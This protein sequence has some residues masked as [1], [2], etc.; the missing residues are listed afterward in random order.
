MG[1]MRRGALFAGALFAGALFGARQEEGASDEEVL[2]RLVRFQFLPSKK[3]DYEDED[4]ALMLAA[5]DAL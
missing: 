2:R 3:V 5:L 4:A 1:L